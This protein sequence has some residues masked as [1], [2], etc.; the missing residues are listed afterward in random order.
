[1]DKQIKVLI[2]DDVVEMQE[3]LKQSLHGLGCNVDAIVSNGHEALKQINLIQPDIAFLDIDMPIKTGIDVLEELSVSSLQ[4]YPVIV[5][6]LSTTV[7]VKAALELGAKGFV[8]KPYTLS[9]LEQILNKFKKDSAD[10]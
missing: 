10:Y 3:L 8:V 6:G 4:V 9:K 7:N 2:A 5:S 1:M